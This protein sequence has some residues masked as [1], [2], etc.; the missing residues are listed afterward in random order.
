VEFLQNKD[1]LSLQNLA[2]NFA[3]EIK[4]IQTYSQAFTQPENPLTCHISQFLTENLRAFAQ[5]YSQHWISEDS[6][7]I[8]QKI[9]RYALQSKSFE[10]EKNKWIDEL[11][12][13]IKQK[14][15]QNFL[16]N[17]ILQEDTSKIFKDLLERQEVQEFL[18]KVLKEL[19]EDF[20]PNLLACLHPETKDFLAFNVLEAVFEALDENLPQLLLSVDL[21]KVVV[22]EIEAMH[23][24][25]VEALFNSF[26]AIYFRELINYGFGFGVVFGLGLD[27]TLK[28]IES[29]MR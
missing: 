15:L 9:L 8:A 25:E 16:E 26:A 27:L 5:N 4:L 2:K 7:V 20:L 1:L 23:P 3:N 22:E 13:K 12:F 28:G 17:K 6:E 10:Q 19:V 11:F 18:R 29:M 21:H 24:K 14:P